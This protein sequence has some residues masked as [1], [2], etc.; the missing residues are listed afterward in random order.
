MEDE[1]EPVIVPPDR[2]SASL[3]EAL[4]EEFVTREGTDYG[5]E[6]WTLE[7]KC[8]QVKRDVAA[9]RVLIAFDP[10]SGTTNLLPVD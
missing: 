5:H 1:V 10:E 2:L 4:I 9:G 6:Q 3:L 7:R 8:E